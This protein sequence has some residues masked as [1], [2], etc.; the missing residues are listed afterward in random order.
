MIYVLVVTLLAC[1]ALF[2]A[3][4]WYITL[5]GKTSL[6]ICWEDPRYRPSSSITHNLR[7]VYGTSNIF[8]CLLPSISVLKNPGHQWDSF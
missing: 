8:K 2:S 7:I 3:Y 6:E 5:L 4:H 1:L